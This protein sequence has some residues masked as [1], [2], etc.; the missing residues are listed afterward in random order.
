MS[1]K[2]IEKLKK[3]TLFCSYLAGYVDG[4]GSIYG[5]II[6]DKS[7]KNDFKFVI[8]LS[9][10][11]KSSRKW[12]LLKLKKTFDNI[13]Y[14]RE[15]PLMSDYTI[16]GKKDVLIILKLLLPYLE[17]KKRTCV[18]GIEVLESIGTVNTR[19]DFIRVCEKLDK[20]AELTDGK[21]RII[22]KEYVLNYY[23]KLIE[24]PV[25]TS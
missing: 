18:L 5:Q 8:K 17:L 15:G 3:D 21:K 2:T 7:C 9:F 13:G 12:F 20:M 24:T 10:F 6:K 19:D 23:K 1:N 22:N 25:E 11:Q 4:D 14:L 16:S